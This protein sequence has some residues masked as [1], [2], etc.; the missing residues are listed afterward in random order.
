MKRFLPLLLATALTACAGG[1]TPKQSVYAAYGSYEA[2]LS[3]SVAYANTPSADPAI[4]HRMAAIN[5]SADTKAAVKYGRAFA[6]CQGDNKTVVSAIDCS[7]FD[8]RATT[9]SGYASKLRL[10]IAALQA[11]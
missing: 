8:F 1:L 10:A 5:D 3:T 4:V 7:E 2:V 11:R 9:A 6:A